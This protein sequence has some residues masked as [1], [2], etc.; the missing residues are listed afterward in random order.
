MAH[1]DPFLQNVSRKLPAD[2]GGT[3]DVIAHGSPKTV[4]MQ[5]ARG[6]REIDHRIAARL[7][8]NHPD[9]SGQPIR[10]LS[11]STGNC[12]TGFAQGLADQLGTTVEAPTDILWAFNSGSMMVAPRLSN[13]PQSSSYNEPKRSQPGQFKTFTPTK[14]KR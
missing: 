8:Q 12:N 10:L 11:C 9:Y 7:I 6:P 13:N 5:T 1:D 14:G 3:F 4:E 2:A